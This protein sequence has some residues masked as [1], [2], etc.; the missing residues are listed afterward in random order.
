MEK[1]KPLMMTIIVLLVVVL[2][3]V[4]FVVYSMQ[5]MA[6]YASSEP[7]RT[8]GS[9]MLTLDQIEK[10]ALSSPIS[11]NLLGTGGAQHFVNINLAVGVNNTDTRDSPKILDSLRSSEAVIR[12]VVL[13]VIRSQ[14]Y[15][16]LIQ[17][18]GQDLLREHIK[19]QLQETFDSNL[20]V[21]VFIS[22]LVFS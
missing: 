21:Q 1:I 15:H 10:V 2:G 12:D 22:D 4:G 19:T 6:G 5:G 18:E 14:S 11:T 8:E 3:G 20:I 16:D 17:P 7:V 13:G 9:S